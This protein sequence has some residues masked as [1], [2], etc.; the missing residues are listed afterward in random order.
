MGELKK[1]RLASEISIK[2]PDVGV[3]TEGQGK[4]VDIEDLK[5]QE[6]ME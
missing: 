6:E 5:K 4:W 3:Q 2:N 1:E